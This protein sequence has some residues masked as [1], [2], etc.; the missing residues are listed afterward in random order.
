MSKYSPKVRAVGYVEKA[1]TRSRQL[2]DEMTSKVKTSTSSSLFNAY[3]EQVLTYI[4][5]IHSLNTPYQPNLSTYSFNTTYQSNSSTHL[6][7]TLSTHP[8][9]TLSTYALNPLSQ[10]TI[11]PLSQ[12]TH[13]LCT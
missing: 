2:V 10:P 1:R 8:Q 13:S 7:P 6:Q 3:V 11:N 12:H 9:R 4:S 5:L